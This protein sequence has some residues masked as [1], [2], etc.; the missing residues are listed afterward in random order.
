LQVQAAE[1]ILLASERG[2]GS[3]P[4]VKGVGE[5]VGIISKPIEVYSSCSKGRDGKG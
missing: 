5:K 1:E 2:A 4:A 3:M